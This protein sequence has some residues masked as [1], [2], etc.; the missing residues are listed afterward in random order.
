MR[1]EFVL[2]QALQAV[3]C[4]RSG[5]R[6]SKRPQS[7]QPIVTKEDEWTIAGPASKANGAIEQ[8]IERRHP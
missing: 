3:S 8:N 5:E 7:V 2:R 1:D 6:L 4:H